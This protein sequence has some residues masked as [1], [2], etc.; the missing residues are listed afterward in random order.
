MARRGPVFFVLIGVAALAAGFYIARPLAPHAAGTDVSPP[1]T[2][3][4]VV[5][6]GHVDIDGG[7]TAISPPHSGRVM[8][9]TVAEGST[10]EAGA[11]LLKLDDRP[12]RFAADEA[13][14]AL[15]AAKLRLTRAEQDLRQQPSRAAQLRAA[16]ES[17]EQRLAAARY[18]L[19]RQQELYKINNSNLQDV[20]SADSLVREHEAQ[21]R[22]AKERLAEFEQ[23]DPKLPVQEART[24]LAAAESQVR[25]AEYAVDQCE[26]RA[27]SAGTVLQIQTRAGEVVGAAGAVAPIL[28]CPDRPFIVR[29]EVEQEF[30]R[31]LKVGQMARVEDESA[32]GPVWTGRLARIAGWYAARRSTTDKPSAF[33]DVPTVE[34]IIQLDDRRPPLRVG[35]RVQ[36]TIAN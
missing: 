1:V 15:G 29:A 3:P 21:V 2:A 16:Q 28:F 8:T 35:Q 27:P 20:R 22:A 14:A 12:A 25:S 17:A 5:C 9:V 10:V 4:A 23:T 11:V 7:V 6:L 31:R 18:Q 36:V 34:C 13:R 19:E 24:A 33:K 26:V 32:G 30:V